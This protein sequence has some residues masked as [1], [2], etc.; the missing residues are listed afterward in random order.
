MWPVC[1]CLW[2]IIVGG[3]AGFLVGQVIRGKGY[4]PIGNVLLGMMGRVLFPGAEPEMGLPL[5]IRNVL[6]IGVTGLVLAA[7]F[8]AIMSTADS[9]LLASVGNVVSDFYLR[10][11]RR[12]PTDVDIPAIAGL[13][14]RRVELGGC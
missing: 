10:A 2:I 6:P 3:T 14:Q 12:P 13:K 11:V 7:Y 4:N 8:S 5:L 9:C 1:A